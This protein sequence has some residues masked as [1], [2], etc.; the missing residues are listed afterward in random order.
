MRFG[1]STCL[2]AV[3]SR[4]LAS[5]QASLAVN[6]KTA[7]QPWELEAIERAKVER[8]K[9]SEESGSVK[10]EMPSIDMNNICQ[11]T[12][13]CDPSSFLDIGPGFQVKYRTGFVSRCLPKACFQDM[14]R[15]FYVK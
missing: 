15:V 11:I 14:F 6:S 9:F 3:R 4:Q 13:A 1:S 10:L 5:D 7:R 2:L 12:L 8:S